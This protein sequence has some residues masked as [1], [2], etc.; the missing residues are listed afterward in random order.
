MPPSGNLLQYCCLKGPVR[1]AFGA[2]SGHGF[3]GLDWEFCF[4]SR[5][6]IFNASFF[7]FICMFVFFYFMFRFVFL[8]GSF[9]IVIGF[10]LSNYRIV[11]HL[12]IFCEYVLSRPVR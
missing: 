10:T 3:R 1:A 2:L 7:H 6:F 11:H 5:P 8:V 9:C 4:N 12:L